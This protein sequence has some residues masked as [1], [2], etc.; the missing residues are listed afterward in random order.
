MPKLIEQIHK[1]I[2]DHER[3]ADVEAHAS[4]SRHRA[5]VERLDALLAPDRH[6]TVGRVLVLVRLQSLHAR[7][8]HIHR[9]V[10]EHRRRTGDHTERTDQ[11]LR[12][13]TLRIVALVQVTARF[14]HI[15]SDGLIGALLDD[16][17][18]Q[19]FVHAG[20]ALVADDHRDAVHET[21]ELRLGRALV[22]DE[23]HLD[24]FH[25]CDGQN[26]FAHAGTETGEEFAAC[27]EL[28]AFVGQLAAE[29][30]ECAESAN[31]GEER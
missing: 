24:G 17:R 6:R 7:L 8:H 10:A 29:G 23:L 9:R 3:D 20:Q 21:A 15:E 4:Q 19:T 16:R 25:R 1:R 13:R 30:F 2:V 12:H 5:L 18:A 14:H 27:R 28:A 22:V 11:Q 26:G 31:G